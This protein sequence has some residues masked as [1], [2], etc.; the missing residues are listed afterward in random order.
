MVRSTN[1]AHPGRCCSLAPYHGT[2][3]GVQYST[4]PSP[5][6]RQHPHSRL[7]PNIGFFLHHRQIICAE[8][9]P[10]STT[11]EYI[12]PN[13]VLCHGYSRNSEELVNIKSFTHTPTC[14]HGTS[15]WHANYKNSRRST[16]GRYG[17]TYTHYPLTLTDQK[18]STWYK[19]LL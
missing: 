3:G 17:K 10:V 13:S 4:F 1:P 19:V 5:L 15:P 11:S 12:T 6:Y 18:L 7:V 14:C 16:G 2:F 8:Y 9:P